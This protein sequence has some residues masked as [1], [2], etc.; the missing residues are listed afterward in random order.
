MDVVVSPWV[1]REALKH[2]LFQAQLVNLALEWVAEETGLGVR[3]D[4]PCVVLPAAVCSYWDSE[5]CG[6]GKPRPFV[7]DEVRTPR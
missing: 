2:R 4:G 1:V 7:L 5:Q 6:I 3:A